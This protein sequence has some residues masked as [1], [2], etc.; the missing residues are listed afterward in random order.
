[1]RKRGR[2]KRN[3][4][5]RGLRID[6]KNNNV[7]FALKKFKRMVKDSGLMLE[8]KKRTYYEK[9]S[10][11]QREKTLHEV[12][13]EGFEKDLATLLDYAIAYSESSL[14]YVAVIH[15]YELRKLLINL[16]Q[17]AVQAGVDEQ[18]AEQYDKDREILEA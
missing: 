10:V 9:P 5:K 7:D 14:N 16:M 11:K 2:N 18:Q 1:M 4:E 13:M 6:V 12:L 3:Q 17:Q 8:L 15:P